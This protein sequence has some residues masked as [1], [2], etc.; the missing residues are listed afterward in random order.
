MI[1][2]DLT[3]AYISAYVSEA[4]LSNA[5]QSSTSCDK[6]LCLTASLG[7]DGNEGTK[8]MTKKTSESAWWSVSIE[9]NFSVHQV[10]LNAN[11]DIRVEL[12]RGD[13]VVEECETHCIVAN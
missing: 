4:E 10:I 5:E 12:Y 6:G 13:V 7:I 3:P 11:S 1:M 8:S 9:L 2:L